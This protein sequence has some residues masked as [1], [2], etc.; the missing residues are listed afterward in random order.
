MGNKNAQLVLQYIVQN[1]LKSDVAH[2]T[3]HES[4]LF[5]IKLGCCKLRTVVAESRE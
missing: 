2:F 3:T 4:N 1:E 5:R